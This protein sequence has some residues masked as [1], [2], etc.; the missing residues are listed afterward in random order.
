[1][2]KTGQRICALFNADEKYSYKIEQYF[3]DKKIE[4]KKL[5]SAS[6]NGWGAMLAEISDIDETDLQTIKSMERV[7]KVRLI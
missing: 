2:K 3:L 1:M 7:T 6:K 5:S 4:I